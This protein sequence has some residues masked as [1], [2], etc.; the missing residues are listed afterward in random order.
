[1]AFEHCDVSWPELL[2]NTVCKLIKSYIKDVAELL[3]LPIPLCPVDVVHCSSKKSH[4]K[5]TM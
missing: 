1:M 5:V 3:C 4:M 2:V